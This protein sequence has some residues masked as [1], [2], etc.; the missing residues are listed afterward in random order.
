MVDS[1]DD[2]APAEMTY[3]RNTFGYFAFATALCGLVFFWVPV[4]GVSLWALGLGM[5]FVGCFKAPRGFGV[6]GVF[7]SLI[8]FVFMGYFLVMPAWLA[9]P[10]EKI[11]HREIL[12]EKKSGGSNASGTAGSLLSEILASF[13][14]EDKT[15]PA[16]TVPEAAPESAVDESPQ[17]DDEVWTDDDSEGEEVPGEATLP[18]ETL[19]NSHAF[20]I[21]RFV[22]ISKHRTTW[23]RWVRLT[24]SRTISLWDS[25]RKEIMGKMEVPAK[26]VVEVLDVRPDGS[27]FVLDCT[28]QAF[29]VLAADTDF[30]RVYTEKN[31]Q[32]SSDEEW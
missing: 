13:H 24:R 29:V 7:V 30:A 1:H 25:E 18:A 3:N 23:P 32:D 12:S 17:G 6:S 16:K 22:E 21:A 8:S 5:S 10:V 2:V 20:P 19:S 14:Y 31:T 9:V 27:I 11:V 4:A 26:T 28:Q 15:E